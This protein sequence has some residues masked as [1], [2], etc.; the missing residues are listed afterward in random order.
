MVHAANAQVAEDVRA[1]HGAAC[2]RDARLEAGLGVRHLAVRETGV[3]IDRQAVGLPQ[4]RHGHG[5][6]G[7]LGAGEDHL[8]RPHIQ[9]MG[10]AAITDRRAGPD[11]LH[12]A[13]PGEDLGVLLDQGSRERSRRGG[14][15]LRHGSNRDRQ[16]HAAGLK[17]KIHAVVREA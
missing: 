14:P 8:R 4:L 12:Q 6:E 10:Y 17:E 3:D 9:G 16:G 7:L 5:H 13:Y 1:G 2:Q 11:E 15:R